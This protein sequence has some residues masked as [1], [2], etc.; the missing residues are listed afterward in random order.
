MD[1]TLSYVDELKVPLKRVL[2]KALYVL[3]SRKFWFALGSLY[4][5][6]V[7]VE[8][9]PNAVADEAMKIIGGVA[10][11]IALIAATAW[12]DVARS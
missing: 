7:G 10:T 2:V 5:L 12:E 3:Q 4:F 9:D 8:G 6:A 11:M 1:D